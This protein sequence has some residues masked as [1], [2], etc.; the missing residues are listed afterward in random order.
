[1]AN[2][3]SSSPV[4]PD[5]GS[6]DSANDKPAESRTEDEPVVVQPSGESK[7]DSSCDGDTSV[8][9]E[10]PASNGKINSNSDVMLYSE[11]EEAAFL[12]SLGWEETAEEEGLTEEEINSFYRDVSKVK[13]HIIP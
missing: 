9:T 4:A 11:E 10:T 1:M 5:T 12:R 3:S 13:C 6:S 7:L 2:H 8:V